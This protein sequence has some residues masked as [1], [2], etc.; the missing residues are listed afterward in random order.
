MRRGNPSEPSGIPGP[1][2]APQELRP[3]YSQ[4]FLQGAITV[5]LAFSFLV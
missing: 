5:Q 3:F 2:G 4:L 1:G